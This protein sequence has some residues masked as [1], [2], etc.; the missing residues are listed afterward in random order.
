L[1]IWVNTSIALLLQAGSVVLGT[2]WAR[3]LDSLSADLPTDARRGRV[4]LG[5]VNTRPIRL[6]G[7]KMSSNS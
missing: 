5:R 6:H 1:R 2:L 3:L 4:G 7:S